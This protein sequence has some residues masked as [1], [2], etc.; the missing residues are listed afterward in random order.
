MYHL[1]DED[2]VNEPYYRKTQSIC[3]ECLQPIGAEV[4]EDDEQIYMRKTCEEHGDFKDLISSSAKY[5]KWTHYAIKDKNGNIK[6]QFDK[7]GESNPPDFQGDDPRGCPYNC[8][9]CEQHIST[10]SLALIDLTN[11]CNFN[12]NFCYANILQSGYLVQPTLEEIDRIMKHFRSKPIPAVAIMF[13]GGE[14]TVRKDFPEICKMAKDNGFKEVIVATNGYGFQRKKGGLEFTKKCKEMGLDTLYFQ[15]DGI[16]DATYEK[17]RGIKNLMSYKQRVVDNLRKARLDSTVLVAT[18]A[19]GVTDVEV[20]N[21]IQYAIDNIDVIRGITFQPVSLCGR[22]A[23]EERSELRITN[24]DILKEIEKQTG[25]KVSMENAWYPLS[26]IVEF[27]RVIAYLADVEPIEFTCH[28]DCG[29]ASYMVVDPDSGEMM[30][31]MDYFDPLKVIDFANRFWAKIK[32]KEKQPIKLFEGLLGDFGKTLDK[33]LNYLDKTQ[34]KAR[35]LLGI[36]QYMKKPGKLMELFSRLLMRGDWESI[37]S[38]SYG[39]LLLSSMHFQDAY[40][41]DLERTKRCIVHFGVAMPDGT[42]KEI[43]FC[44]MNTIHRPEIEKQIAKQ[45]SSKVRDEFD[46]TTGQEVSVTEITPEVARNGGIKKEE[47]L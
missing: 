26:T 25:G 36:L 10:C 12:C 21:I 44:T 35:F 39:A 46:T 30:P 32:N 31:I 28:P 37:S 9:L 13:T 29:F 34:L 40:N 43:S 17:T 19:K 45:I 2:Y 27:G 3:P 22:I 15:F 14:P 7:D 38:F 6:W 11:R 41:M 20:G 16:N 18:I 33:G 1:D 23:F 42:V 24:A 47:E 4:Y 8:G 5:Y